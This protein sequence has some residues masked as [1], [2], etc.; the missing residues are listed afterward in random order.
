MGRGLAWAVNE[1]YEG[2]VSTQVYDILKQG[3]VVPAL[4]AGGAYQHG[5][6]GAAEGTK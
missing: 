5:C 6:F 4:G 3:E 1:A 2:G